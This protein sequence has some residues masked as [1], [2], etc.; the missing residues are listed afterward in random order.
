M[1]NFMTTVRDAVATACT[2]LPTI[3]TRVHKRDKYP[4]QPDE[5]P[6][7]LVL[8]GVVPESLYVDDPGLLQVD[9]QI[10][11]DAIAAA[12]GDVGAVLDTIAGE[13][14][15]ALAGLTSIGGRPVTVTWRASPV[16]QFA[17]E[18]DPPAA[19]RRLSFTAGPLFVHASA[20]DALV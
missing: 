16:P 18:G 11:I 5:L 9:A 7:V 19:R 17:G 1:P 4:W 10:E 8:V 12:P 2:G 13:V 20:P 15:A 6:G 3:G 14:T